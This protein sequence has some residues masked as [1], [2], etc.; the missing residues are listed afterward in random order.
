MNKNRFGPGARRVFVGALLASTAIVPAYA[1]APA[2]GTAVVEEVIVTAT[3]RSENLQNV[4]ISVQALSPKVLA[5]H[6]VASF[7]DYAKL[8]P[9][10]SFQSFGPGQSQPYFR[11][12]TSAGDGLHSGSLPGSGVYLDETPVTT[13]GNGLDLHLYDIARVEALS[14]PQGTLFGASSLSGTLRI[15]TNQPDPT[16]FSAAFDVQ[17]DKFGPGGVGGVT[18]GYVNAPITD[19][20]AIRLVAFAEH[21]GG[22]IDNVLKSRT[23]HLTDGSTLP[24]NNAKF[25][26]KSFNDTDTYG[27]RAALKVDLNDQWSV[28][29]SV[30][31]QSQ[32]AHGNFLYN[33]KVGDLKIS[34]FSPEYNNDRW[35]QAGLTIQGKLGNWDVLYAGGY[36][37]R[38]VDNAADYSYYA[39]AY[40]AAG[41]SSYVTFPDGHN[42]FLDPDQQFTSHDSYTKE[43][44]ELRFTSPSDYRLRAVGGVFYERQA[45]HIIANYIVPGLAASGDPRSIPG[46]GDDIYYTNIER[47]DRDFALFGESSFDIL[48]NLTLTAGARYF[49]VD[50][51]LDG[52]SGFVGATNFHRGA[53]EYGETHKLNLSWKIDPQHMVY[54]TYS[55]G[56]RPGGAN[57]RTVAPPYVPDA[58]T[59]YEIGAK[60]TWLDNRLRINGAIF[61]EEWHDV[62]F[63][64]SPVGFQGVTFI[65]NVGYAR[66]WGGEG[67]VSYHLDEHW[68]LSG[69]GTVLQAQL[70]KT[71]CDVSG[72]CAFAG[73]ELPIQ[74]RYKFSGTA[75][76][77]FD[78]RDYK[79]F[80]QGSLQT[81]GD[82]RSALLSGDEAR[83]G[84]TKG[85]TTVDLS[86]G[87]ARDNWNVEAF[88]QNVFDERGI[89]SINVD[90]SIT[91]CGPYPLSYPT[92]PQFFGIK[93]GAKY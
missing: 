38:Q 54:A 65:Y 19:K 12:I 8:L 11:G 22:Y 62:Q 67:D 58:I 85:F 73:S 45:D 41:A 5:D 37:G 59:N 64:L 29:P 49:T 27:G 34:D 79:S 74:P 48:S 92:K 2:S 43:T 84:P 78:F 66:S 7:D 44:H 28:T 75:R 47:I 42:G 90:C 4:P 87:F 31:Y 21:D 39:V 83:L 6:Q 72:N 76:Y 24:E 71:F 10:V 70:T 1:A 81:Q 14:G 52:L 57:R 26:K 36:L 93:F 55:T 33:P 88:V 20:I 17:G 25:V 32:N 9:S 89:L 77:D 53:T 18:E 13:I 82:T 23:F 40:D 68:T 30:V 91:Y 15:I 69:S 35:Y 56:F 60:T 80:F 51:T 46:A 3:K 63:A 16:H 86:A 50:N 61:D